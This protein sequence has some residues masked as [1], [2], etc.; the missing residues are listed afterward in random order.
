MRTALW[1][2]W[3]KLKFIFESNA[4]AGNVG[5]DSKAMTLGLQEFS[6]LMKQTRLLN[7]EFNLARIDILFMKIDAKYRQAGDDSSP[8]RELAK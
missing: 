7:K 3:D 5:E 8:H 2:G 6:K 1:S 4:A